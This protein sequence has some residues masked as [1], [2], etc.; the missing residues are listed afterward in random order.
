MQID[1]LK[2]LVKAATGKRA[3]KNRLVEEREKSR[4]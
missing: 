3:R 4:P 1:A 2:N